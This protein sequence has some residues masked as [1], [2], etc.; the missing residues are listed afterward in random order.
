MAGRIRSIKPELLEDEEAAAAFSLRPRSLDVHPDIL[1]APELDGVSS[2][3]FR[4][5]IELW[6]LRKVPSAAAASELLSLGLA[7]IAA[8]GHLAP[9]SPKAPNGRALVKPTTAWSRKHCDAVR[10]RDGGRC[11]YCRA[12]AATI[13][14]V[15]PR[16][17]GGSDDLENLVVCCRN[18]NSKKWAR[19][20]EQAGMT[21]LPPAEATDA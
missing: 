2:S 7:K 4:A 10:V 13:D 9:L 16:A 8:H 14:H 21:L 18:C 11:R 1:T 20:P 12:P 5:W 17:Q 15:A 19:T 3:A 6:V